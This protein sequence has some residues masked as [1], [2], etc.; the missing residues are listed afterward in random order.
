MVPRALRA[1]SEKDGEEKLFL[2]E[3]SQVGAGNVNT[4]EESD[5]EGVP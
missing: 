4:L 3:E 1:M 2:G 5:I